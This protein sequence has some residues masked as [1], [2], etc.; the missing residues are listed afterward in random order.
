MKDYGDTAHQV[1]VLENV[2][3]ETEEFAYTDI[4]LNLAFGIWNTTTN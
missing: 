2:L 1:S 3:D 4:Q